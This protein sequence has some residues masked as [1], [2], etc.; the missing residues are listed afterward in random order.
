MYNLGSNQHNDYEE[1]QQLNNENYRS[2]SRSNAI[3][4]T[5]AILDSL[6]QQ[7]LLPPKV[8]IGNLESKKQLLDNKFQNIIQNLIEKKETKF[9]DL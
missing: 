9:A 2:N 3:D 8:M 5:R 4:E 7:K 1:N 6:R